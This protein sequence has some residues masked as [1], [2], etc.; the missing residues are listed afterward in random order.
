M[1]RVQIAARSG[2]ISAELA[3][4]A[5]DAAI[6]IAELSGR[7]ST[8]SVR[9]AWQRR[10]AWT[11]Y[12]RALQLQGGEIDEID[13][14][15]WG[16]GVPLPARPRRHTHDDEFGSFEIWWRQLHSD[17][18]ASWR[19]TFPFTIEIDHELPR[20]LQ[21]IDVTR[22]YAIQSGAIEPWLALPR[23]LYLLRV[24]TSPLPCLVAGAKAFRARP[25]L[26]ED[27][28]RAALKAL[29]NAARAGLL[30]LDAMEASHK[31]ALR[32][33]ISEYRPGKLPQLFALGLSIAML[34]P[35]GVADHLGLTIAGA[36]KLLDRA[37]D[38]GML[39]EITGRRAWKAYVAPDLAI[40]LG[41]RK[42]TLGRPRNE[43]P[44]LAHSR[45]LARTLDA[46]DRELADIAARFSKFVAP[47][48]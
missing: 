15:S 47:P 14:F 6:A 26:S 38:L 45:E 44:P 17:D 41:F 9:I 43:P 30:S 21:A 5:E 1:A 10:A 7:I 46:F 37:A 20:I 19:D 28:L 13:V 34:S 42:P 12:A 22:Q 48:P 18:H 29:A 27:A 16:A 8:S 23:F 2:H 39:V 3:R 35:K 4:S 31:A 33:I 24:T 25:P 40:A 36:G 11:G 32:A